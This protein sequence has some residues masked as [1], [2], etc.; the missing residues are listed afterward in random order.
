MHDGISKPLNRFLVDFVLRNKP[1]AVFVEQLDRYVG[2]VDPE[3]D[4]G[5][6]VHAPHQRVEVFDEDVVFVHQPQRLC[7]PAP[8]ADG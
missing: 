5:V 2:L 3:D 4:D 1:Y 7:K 8:H 6:G